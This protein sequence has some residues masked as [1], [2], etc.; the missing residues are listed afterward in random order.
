MKTLKFIIDIKASPQKVWF[1]L[2][3]P[4]NYKSWISP[5]GE[6]SHYKADSFEKDSKIHFLTPEG[7]G[8]HCKIAALNQ[9]NLVVFEY[10]SAIAS[11]KEIP[12]ASN[13]NWTG[14]KESYS[15][16]KTKSG[17]TLTILIDTDS[18]H[19]DYMNSTIPKALQLLKQLAE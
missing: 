12:F 17:T 18:I 5:F 1:F 9:P 6:G 19:L 10:V 16:L 8:V 7:E 14:F 4:E 13:Q 2:W 15:L 3:E 11:F